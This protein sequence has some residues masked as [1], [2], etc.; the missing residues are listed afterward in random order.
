MT[1]FPDSIPEQLRQM[2]N[3]LVWRLEGTEKVPYDPKSKRR[4]N[5]TK[6]RAGQ[7]FEVAL[8]SFERDDSFSGVGFIFKGDGLVGIDLDD[9]IQDGQIVHS[10]LEILKLVD[11]GYVEIS[12][13]GQ[14]VHGIG[15]CPE[16]TQGINT[17]LDDYG[18]EVYKEARYFTVTGNLLPGISGNGEVREMPALEQVVQYIR[19]TPTQVTQ[20][21]QVTKENQVI[22][23]SQVTQKNI[24]TY[25]RDSLRSPYLFNL[26][27]RCFPVEYGQRHRAVF[28][29]ARYLRTATPNATE[30]E[31]YEIVHQWFELYNDAIRTKDFGVTWSD[32]ETAWD[33]VAHPYLESLQ[34]LA[35]NPAPLPDWMQGHRYGQRADRLLRI[36][37]TLAEHHA[38]EAFFL[39]AR[40]AQTLT[41]IDF[42]DCAKFFK[43]FVKKGYLI[44]HSSNPEPGKMRLKEGVRQAHQYYI[45]SPDTAG[46]KQ[47]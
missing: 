1:I 33:S 23:E 45:G 21:T 9:C 16:L 17:K 3:W 40:T 14:G 24:E 20:V 34:G 22:Q 29:L 39:S 11:C 37:V 4:L 19:E 43:V 7:P 42:S 28:H 44:S 18:F 27:S 8:E 15:L 12:P 47:E 41:G 32:F 6:P 10:A 5:F 35:A 25:A 2:P 26:P 31:L 38:P 36:C 13:S 46:G 30:D